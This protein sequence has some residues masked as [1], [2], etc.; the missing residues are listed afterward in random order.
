MFW[1]PFESQDWN[2][3]KINPKLVGKSGIYKDVVNCSN[4]QSEYQFRPNFVIA[5]AVAPEIFDPMH[6]MHAL[7]MVETY[8]IVNKLYFLKFRIKEV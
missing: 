4:V 7:N 8:L 5:M 2:E 6:A 3:Y 1:I